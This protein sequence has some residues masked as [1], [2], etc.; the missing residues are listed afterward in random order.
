MSDHCA[1]IACGL[2][3]YYF[4]YRPLIYAVLNFTCPWREVF[5]VWSSW[6]A[7]GKPRDP[8]P[9]P[10]EESKKKSFSIDRSEEFFASFSS[11]T[12]SGKIRFEKPVPI[13]VWINDSCSDID[14][15]QSTGRED[16]SPELSASS[17][18]RQTNL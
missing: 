6:P 9:K 13:P 16:T 17:I 3:T 4:N 10:M 2:T 14:N 18:L 1:R 7:L 11:R 12:Y 8:K 5:F 15:K